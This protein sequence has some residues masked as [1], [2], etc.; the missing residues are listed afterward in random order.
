[1]LNWVN[2]CHNQY[3]PVVR[4]GPDRLSYITA[5]AWKDIHGHRTRG[6]K[7]CQK[8]PKFYGA[9]GAVGKDI[10]NLFDDQYHGQV[11]R[12]F[13]HAF[14]DKA[15]KEQETMLAKYV[16][17][18]I[19]NLRRIAHKKTDM[20]KNYN[21]TT[22]DIMG[23][24]AFGEPL[25]L[26]KNGE[27]SPWVANVFEKVKMSALGHLSLEYPAIG[28]VLRMLIPK[29]STEAAKMHR[30]HAAERVDRR[31]EMGNENPDIWNL[32]LR[33]EDEQRLSL[34]EMYA[35]ADVF[36]V[37]GTETTAT[38]LSGL[39]Y[40]L[41]KN[42]DKMQKL[43]QEIRTSFTSEDEI[44][45]DKLRALKYMAACFEEGLRCYPPAP[46]GLFRVVP[47]GGAPI[48]GEYLP[49]SVSVRYMCNHIYN[50][51]LPRHAYASRNMPLFTPN[52]ISSMPMPLFPSAGWATGLLVK[53]TETSCNPFHTDREP[54]SEK[55]KSALH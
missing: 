31:L 10:F 5:E 32:I 38:L 2:D 15:L 21:F 34:S 20:V 51:I 44:M 29:S 30:R 24:L 46:N 49:G 40:Y 16:D 13:S 55:G 1:M 17:M 14:S 48:C 47:E 12:I 9:P 35:N 36:M 7:S 18:L 23:D 26:L 39:T 22:F 8:D 33:Q 54:A 27:Y 6:K 19:S 4:L 45:I 43:V 52:Q 28:T 25:G 3:G 42:P 41:L 11:R 53:T 37:A 50:L